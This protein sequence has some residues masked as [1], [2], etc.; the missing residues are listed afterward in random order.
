MTKRRP[1]LL[2]AAGLAVLLALAGGVCAR[3]Y[4]TT[5]PDARLRSGEEALRRGDEAAAER[6]VL[7]L[8]AAGAKDHAYLLRG[9]ICFHRAKPLLDAGQESAAAPLLRQALEAWNR[10]RDRG[11]VRLRAA[12]LSG[13]CFLYLGEPAQAQRA[14]DFVVAERPD[15]VDAHRGLAAIYYDQ[16]A[17]KQAL[18]H[19]DEVAR[20]DP[21]DGRPHRLMGVILAELDQPGEAVPCF[22]EA[23]R[24]RLGGQATAEARVELAECLV[25]L[26]EYDQA[27]AALEG[28]EGQQAVALRAQ[29]LWEQGKVA[30]AR[31]LLDQALAAYPGFGL[32][33]HLRARVHAAD[34]EPAAAAAL[35]E[36]ALDLDRHDYACRY[37]LAQV[38]ETLG[39]A[40]DAAEQRQ[41]AEKTK[42][43]LAEVKRLT[44]DAVNRPADA[45]VR[46]RLA[47]LCRQ[48]D[49]PEQARLWLQAAEAAAGA[50]PP[51]APGQ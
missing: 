36:R 45:A 32:L 8:Q 6:L 12:A 31:P 35:L 26:R 39:R 7:L 40:A 27:R 5:R 20:L 41:L 21:Q 10:I 2:L 24:R 13:Q 14:F 19:L 17:L 38:Y 4:T 30:E 18:H 11:D 46:R 29:C 33:L 47:E 49:K 1:S 34:G 28:S 48:L 50:Q 42:D 37:Q 15:D 22:R 16:G 9:Q 25:K 51:P 43:T 23:L 44:E 3:W